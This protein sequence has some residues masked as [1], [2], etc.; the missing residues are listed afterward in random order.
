M[1]QHG[2]GKKLCRAALLNS[3][4]SLP[5]NPANLIRCSSIFSPFYAA[6]AKNGEDL[7][8]TVKFAIDAAANLAMRYGSARLIWTGN[9]PWI[10]PA[11]HGKY[12]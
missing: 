11:E 2:A 4:G 12:V 6:T 8:R 9:R 5:E 7:T 10:P 3:S 1:S